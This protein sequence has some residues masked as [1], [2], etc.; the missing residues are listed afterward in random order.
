[1]SGRALSGWAHMGGRAGI[2]GCI[3]RLLFA[4]RQ[5]VVFLHALTA[6]GCV[7]LEMA[8]GQDH[9]EVGDEGVQRFA[10]TLGDEDAPASVVP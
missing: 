10:R 6:R 9:R 7:A 5:R 1:M 8:G 4:A 2:G 3:P